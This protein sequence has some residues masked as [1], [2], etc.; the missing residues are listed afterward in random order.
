MPYSGSLTSWGAICRCF[1]MLLHL[2]VAG[3]RKY[4]TSADKATLFYPI[5]DL[6]HDGLKECF[7]TRVQQNIFRGSARN[8][9]IYTKIVKYHEKFYISLEIS[10]EILSGNWQYW[11]NFRALETAPFFSGL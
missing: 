3:D 4:S 1:A 7:S 5:V 6:I 8:S 2:I 10:L 11:S 9:R